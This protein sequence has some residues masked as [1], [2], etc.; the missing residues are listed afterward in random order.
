[1]L[2]VCVG[3]GSFTGLRIG[4]SFAQGV[5][6]GRGIPIVG[7]SNHDILA[8]QAVRESGPLFTIIDARR[9]E[10]YLAE[11]ERDGEKTSRIL[12][13]RITAIA[14]LAEELPASAELVFRSAVI[15]PDNT[16]QMLRDKHILIN[17]RARYSA[18]IAARLGHER[19]Q[20][21]GADNLD[22]LEPMYIRSFA[23]AS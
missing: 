9:D 3:P 17:N 21:S 23:G 11:H 16:T 4:L 22:E 18:G 12:T 10:V 1:L 6:F 19:F 5:C 20:R 2:A 14:D 7:V 13:H 15:L 8:S